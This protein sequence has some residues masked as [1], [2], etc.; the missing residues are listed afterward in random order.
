M[1]LLV[2]D[3]QARGPQSWEPF[4]PRDALR[5]TFSVEDDRL[6]ISGDGNTHEFGYWRREVPVTGG[7]DYQLQVRFYVTGEVDIPLNVLNMVVWTEPGGERRRSPHDHISHVWR[8]NGAVCGE[9]RF[10]APAH[11]TLAEVQLGL[12]FAPRGTVEWESVELN[13]CEQANPRTVRVTAVRWHGAQRASL[14][15]NRTAL[16]QLVDQAASQ[17]SDLV[18]LPEY[19][20]HSGTATGGF[21]AS[22]PVPDGPF[23]RD[24]RP[25]GQRARDKHLCQHDRAGRR[26]HFQYGRAVRPAGQPRGSISQGAP[27]LARGSMGRRDARRRVPRL[28]SRRWQG[29][30]HDL[31]RLL[32]P[33]GEQAAGAAW[34]GAD[35]VPVGRLRA[36]SVTGARHR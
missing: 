11:A 19:A 2:S 32:V 12:R 36:V 21:E 30:D 1:N 25:Q 27:L 17:S 22:E 35:L 15:E 18:L 6:G 29:R 8:S 3:G 24:V 5:P 28:L 33:R 23:L 4:A 7:G 13:P 10:S 34:S 9:G 20:V 31:L 26:P 14:A 16:A